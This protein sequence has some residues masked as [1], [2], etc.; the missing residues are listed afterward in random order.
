LS[1]SDAILSGLAEDVR[2]LIGS[3]RTRVIGLGNLDRA[4]D[5]AGL[6]I[7]ENWKARLERR[8]FLETEA[9]AETVVL[10]GLDDPDAGVFLFVDAADF[11]AAPG[12]A[13][14]FGAGDRGRFRPAYSTHQVPMDLFMELIESRGKE[15]FLLGVQPGSVEPFGDMTGGVMDTVRRLSALAE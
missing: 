12:A 8:A 1:A 7:V 4:D 15:A 6:R 3:G 2:R 13:R 11:G 9:S 14:L 5:G 10:D